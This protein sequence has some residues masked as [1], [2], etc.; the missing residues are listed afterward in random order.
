[1]ASKKKEQKVRV[2][3]FIDY[4]S[5]AEGEQEDCFSVVLT[6]APAAKIEQVKNWGSY[7]EDLVAELKQ[8]GYKAS[9]LG[10]PEVY[11]L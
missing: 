6:D 2:V 7:H 4:D 1:M 8:L 10:K 3:Y 11:N 9:I 5:I